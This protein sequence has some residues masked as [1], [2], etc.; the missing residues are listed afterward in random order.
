MSELSRIY[1]RILDEKINFEIKNKPL[2]AT[3]LKLN[4]GDKFG[5]IISEIK[6]EKG[7]RKN[8]IP[9]TEF[10]KYIELKYDFVS[11]DFNMFFE[12]GFNKIDFNNP[13]FFDNTEKIRCENKNDYLKVIDQKRL[14]EIAGY[15]MDEAVVEM[16]E[17][18]ELDEDKKKRF[19]LFKEL[20]K[21]LTIRLLKIEQQFLNTNG[22]LRCFDHRFTDHMVIK[23]IY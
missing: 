6:E 17:K 13:I 18:K 19:D 11:P 21:E 2:Y 9:I 23:K 8:G 4:K 15:A 5:D 14:S 20:E 3:G 22:I 16:N 12:D 7:V 1:Q 10:I